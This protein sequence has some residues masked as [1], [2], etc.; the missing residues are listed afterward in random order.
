M[1][2][3]EAAEIDKLVNELRAILRWDDIKKPLSDIEREVQPKARLFDQKIMQPVR[4]LLGDKRKLLVSPDGALNLIPF[5]AL[6][7]EQ[8]KYLIESYS[9][10]YLT[11]GRDLLRLKEYLP[12]KQGMMIVANPNYGSMSGE[13][14]SRGVKSSKPMVTIKG[15]ATTPAKEE[16]TPTNAID[17]SQIEFPPLEGTEQEAQALKAMMPE[18]TTM[19]RDQATKAAVQKLNAPSIL[20]VATHGFYLE[21]LVTGSADNMPSL[22]IDRQPNASAMH[23][24]DPLKRSG[25]AL[26]GANLHKRDDNGILTALEVSGLNLW[27]TKLVV[28]SACETGIGEVQNFNGVVGLRRALVLAG[29]ESQ[30]L[31][32]WKVDDEATRDLMIDYYRRL[33]A[34][35]GRSEA[36]R[37]V[38]L[39]MLA[40]PSYQHPYFWASFIESGEWANLDGKR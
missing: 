24:E 21:N 36:L 27:G 19:M 25:L 22:S 17:F 14:V 15:K 33:K 39:K 29:S 40:T 4:K 26:A 35:E 28:L 23:V 32:L 5:A 18:A 8:G 9:L 13:S 2:L 31:S 10:T 12:S 3:G 34:G 7:D 6:V 1:N 16:A 38:Q 30:M 37:Q 11:T 20:H